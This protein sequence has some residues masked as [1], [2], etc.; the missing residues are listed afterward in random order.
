MKKPMSD[1]FVFQPGDQDGTVVHATK[2]QAVRDAQARGCTDRRP[3]RV[4]SGHYEVTG[5]S[6]H[7]YWIVGKR[8]MQSEFPELMRQAYEDVE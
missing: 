3:K 4:M 6:G 8:I 1:W 5:C 2:R 7:Q